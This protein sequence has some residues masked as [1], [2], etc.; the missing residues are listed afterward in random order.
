[1]PWSPSSFLTSLRLRCEAVLTL[2][3]TNQPHEGMFGAH[4]NSALRSRRTGHKPSP[5]PHTLCFSGPYQP[6]RWACAW[7]GHFWG[8]AAKPWVHTQFASKG[9]H[10]DLSCCDPSG[11]A[12]ANLSSRHDPEGVQLLRSLCKPSSCFLERHQVGPPAKNPAQVP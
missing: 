11:H 6:T 9:V 10:G 5:T 3:G 7:Y 2:T 8:P 12:L 4:C 1:M